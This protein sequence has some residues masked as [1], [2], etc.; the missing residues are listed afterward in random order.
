[1]YVGV[2]IAQKPIAYY[3]FD[4]TTNDFS[5]NNNHGIVRGVISPVNDR[6][7]NPC[8]AFH[9]DGNSSFIV[10]PNSHSLE[11]INKS[12]TFTTW[13]KFDNQSSNQWLTILCKG[14]SS[15]E[16]Y[17]NPQYRLQVQ[18]SPNLNT[19]SCDSTL[20]MQNGFS[21]ISF[22]TAFT[23]CD[24][25]FKKHLFETNK[26]CFYALTYDGNTVKA[27]MNGEKVFSSSFN[28]II[29]PNQ[30]SLFIGVDKPGS[31]EFFQGSLDDLRIFDMCLSDKEIMNLYHETRTF[32][33]SIE[34]PFQENI[35]NYLDI[36]ESTKLINYPFPNINNNCNPINVKLIEGKPSGSLFPVGINKISYEVSENGG[37]VERNTFSIIIRDTI[38]PTFFYLPNDTTIFIQPTFNS[39]KYY[40]S[41]PKAKDNCSVKSIKRIKG[42]ASGD[43]LSEGIHEIEYEAIDING[44]KSFASFKVHVVKR[45]VDKIS[46]STKI[47]RDT[48]RIHD[49]ITL[50]NRQIIHDTIRYF[51]T[52]VSLL[53][54]KEFPNLKKDSLSGRKNIVQNII[55]VSETK[56]KISL[57]DD[58]LVDGDTASVY[59]NGK[60]LIER[61]L[62]TNKAIDFDINLLE[63][64]DNE[65]IMYANSLGSIPPNTGLLVFTINDKVYEIGFSSSEETNAKIIL[66]H[67][68]K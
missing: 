53:M 29:E 30:D 1:M 48:I 14:G 16:S 67:S 12:F 66:R 38:K 23:K 58:G 36:N 52:T 54:K 11:S 68:K 9:F 19:F 34:L 8:S 61:K 25:D 35:I 44:N 4:N 7:N 33:P 59:F 15:V 24:V 55:N 3:T 56:L 37:S 5:G 2:T 28:G 10:V 40:Y 46:E 17:F 57:Y 65:L 62:L 43:S 21:T 18:Q 27:Y 45:V 41:Y 64:Q 51:D 50:I 39:I 22:N 20:I 42:Y 63:N 32:K 13:Y 26:W 60:L 6:F 31:T 47:F 49:T